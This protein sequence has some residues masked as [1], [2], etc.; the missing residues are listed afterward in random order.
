MPVQTPALSNDQWNERLHNARELSLYPV[1]IIFTS[2]S[3]STSGDGGTI[4]YITQPYTVP[5]FCGLAQIDVNESAF[6]VFNGIALYIEVSL[7][8][9]PTLVDGITEPSEEGQIIFIQNTIWNTTNQPKSVTFNP[10]TI[11][12]HAYQI[13]YTHLIYTPAVTYIPGTTVILH[14]RQ[15]GLLI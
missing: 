4:H 3:G 11:P 6:P 1:T 14:F 13:V 10:G 2:N 9:A 12:L 5:S 7:R 15:T 8:P